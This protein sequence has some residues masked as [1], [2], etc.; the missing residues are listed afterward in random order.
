MS[1]Q[2]LLQIINRRLKDIY[3]ERA[4]E[5]A[6]V[7]AKFKPLKNYKYDP[8]GVLGVRSR[9]AAV[10]FKYTFAMSDARLR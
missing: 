6:N 10:E 9:K 5:L 7:E 8:S 2:S 4:I 1:Y 3:G